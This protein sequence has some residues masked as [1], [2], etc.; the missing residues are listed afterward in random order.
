MSHA[1]H[2]PLVLLRL[3]KMRHTDGRTRPL[4]TLNARRGQRD[5]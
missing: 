5:N 3:E 1:E 2:A 4:H